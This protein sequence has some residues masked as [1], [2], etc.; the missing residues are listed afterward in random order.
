[1][2]ILSGQFIG[3]LPCHIG[4]LWTHSS[5]LCAVIPEI[6][7]VDSQYFVAKWRVK[8]TLILVDAFV[9]VMKVIAAS[10]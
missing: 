5:D 6:Y 7:G 10:L 4:D 2:A 8:K 9:N 1:M 3:F